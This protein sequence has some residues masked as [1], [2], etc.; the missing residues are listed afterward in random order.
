MLVHIRVMVGQC[1]L[2]IPEFY[3]PAL[4]RRLTR[5]PLRRTGISA[6]RAA[7]AVCFQ[8]QPAAAAHAGS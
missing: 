1:G 6:A 5:D 8:V 4:E 3:G 7:D 2:G